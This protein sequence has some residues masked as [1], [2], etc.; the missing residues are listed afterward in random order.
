LPWR[1]RVN[2]WRGEMPND[3]VAQRSDVRVRA[4]ILWP[5]TS[6]FRIICLAFAAA[7]SYIP[8]TPRRAA[9]SIWRHFHPSRG[10]FRKSASSS[11]SRQKHSKLRVR[12]TVGTTGLPSETPVQWGRMDYVQYQAY[13][14]DP[15]S[16]AVGAGPTYFIVTSYPFPAVIDYLLSRLSYL[17]LLCVLSFDQ[18]ASS[19]ASDQQSGLH[20]HRCFRRNHLGHFPQFVR[21]PE[22]VA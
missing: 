18:L 1:T 3:E 21:R 16:R 19:S 2:E 12:A 11:P 15:S 22:R 9:A 4:W 8:L 17:P 13:A 10:N 5:A 14:A 7:G 20:C 6:P